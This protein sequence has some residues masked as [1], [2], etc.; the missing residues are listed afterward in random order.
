MHERDRVPGWLLR[1]QE[2]AFGSV[3]SRWR[4]GVGMAVILTAVAGLLLLSAMRPLAIILDSLDVTAFIGLFLVNWIGNGGI[5]VPIP[6]ARFVGL[7][8]IF[9]NAV[10]FPSWEVWVISGT[11]MALG[12]LSYYVAGARTARAYA[13]GDT[14]AGDQLAKETGLMDEPGGKPIPLTP[15]IPDDADFSGEGQEGG[16]RAR[17]ERSFQGALERADPVIEKHGFGG[18]FLLSFGP[19][20]LGTAG[21]FMGGL[22]RFGFSRYLAASFAG[23]YLL[24]GLVVLA[25]LLFSEAAR[26][27]QLPF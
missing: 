7:L 13:K 10:L 24:A 5:V 11:A 26:A 15:P 16:L 2:L 27:V 4:L 20:P 25:G 6:G 22:M 12:L 14:D 8:M 19:T 21:A 18:M 1:I 17:F 23:K 3:S 9:Q